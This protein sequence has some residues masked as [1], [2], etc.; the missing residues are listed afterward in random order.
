MAQG[1][2]ELAGTLIVSALFSLTVGQLSDTWLS[3]Q[4]YTSKCEM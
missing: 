2:A 3:N 4:A 1:E